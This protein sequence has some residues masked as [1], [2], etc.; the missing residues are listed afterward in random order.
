VRHLLRQKVVAYSRIARRERLF[1][2]T[3]AFVTRPIQDV[4]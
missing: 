4:D 2:M 1:E 3:V